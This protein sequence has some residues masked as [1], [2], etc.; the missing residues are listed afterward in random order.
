MNCQGEKVVL[1][2]KFP[3]HQKALNDSKNKTILNDL[4]HKVSGKTY[5]IEV[6]LDKSINDYIV[7]DVHEEVLD[8]DITS[9]SNIFGGGEV[10]E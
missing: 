3:F 5:H 7:D 1:K 2:T 4:I 9:I 6:I 10:V 8:L